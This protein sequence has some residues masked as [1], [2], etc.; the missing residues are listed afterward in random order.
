MGT[1]LSDSRGQSA[2]EIT[3]GTKSVVAPQ[4]RGDWTFPL[5]SYRWEM[6]ELS[7]LNVG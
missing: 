4:L 6:A 7:S 5:W 2:T 1:K 3:L